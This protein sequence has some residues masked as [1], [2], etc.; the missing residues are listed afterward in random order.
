MNALKN[1]YK[2]KRVFITG[3]TGFKGSWLCKILL[4]F[5]A[6]ICGY[7]LKPDKISLFNIL[8]LEKNI[9]LKNIFGDIRDLNALK[10]AAKD[11]N[12]DIIIHMAAQPLVLRS[13]QE[14]VYTYET[15]IMGTVNILEAARECSALKSFLNVTTDKVYENKEWPWGYR[16]NERLCGRDPYSNSKSCSELITYSYKKSFFNENNAPAISTARA[17]NVIGGGDFTEDRII[18]DCVKSAL[19]GKKIILRSPKA[20]RPF[21]HVLDC[22]YGYLLLI[23]RQHDNKNFQGNYNFGPDYDDCVTAEFLAQNFCN[24][25]GG[26]L[27]FEVKN[28]NNYQQPHEANILK[29]DCSLAKNILGWRPRWNIKKA[30]AEIV[31]WTKSYRDNGDLNEH[32]DKCVNSFFD[33]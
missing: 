2:N 9:K 28:N 14:P 17:G 30:L 29:L 15:N 32:M 16:E 3:H 25:W 21:Q 12:P 23:M 10:I 18:P 7:A 26:N 8:E 19:S 31:D 22:L 1:F 33:I 27:S 13:Y 24:L 4:N 5:G 11:F 20:I 6:E